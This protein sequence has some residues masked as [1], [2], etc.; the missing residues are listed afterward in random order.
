MIHVTVLGCGGS[1]GVPSLLH[2]WGACD[3]S[4]PR[5]RRGR[6]AIL[7]D[8]GEARLLVDPGPDLREQLLRLDSPDLDA[9]FVTHVHADHVHGIDDLRMLSFHSQ[10]IDAYAQKN[11][12]GMI[13]SNFSYIFQGRYEGGMPPLL[14]LHEIDGSKSIDVNGF[15]VTPVPIYHG[16]LPI[17]G[18]RFGDIGYLT[19]CKTIPDESMQLLEGV[20]TVVIDGL[21]PEP[22]HPTHMDVEESIAAVERIGAKRA[23][24]THMTHQMDYRNPPPLP[25]HIEMAYD[26]LVARVGGDSSCPP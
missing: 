14:T 9:V 17:L 22:P 5:N 12:L 11:V 2:G 15:T 6:S 21:R 23:Y 13:R 1:M 10:G 25:E 8:T 3:R 18:Y 4:E 19:D 7:I 26:G 24:L 20:H 16:K